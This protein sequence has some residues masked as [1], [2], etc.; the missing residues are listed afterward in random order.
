[1][2]A[3]SEL[4]FEKIGPYRIVRLLGKGGMGAV[5]EANHE[6]TDRRVAIK[7]LLPERANDRDAVQRFFNEARAVTQIEH[8]CLVQVSDFGHADDGTAYLVMEYLSGDT[9]T[10]QL[11]DLQSQGQSLPLRS[12]LR[13]AAQCADVLTAAHEQG[14]VHR[15]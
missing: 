12:A 8:P 5:Y 3:V 6:A 14:I 13:I 4:P 2:E 11:S 15:G 7:V 9:L 1:M 10:T